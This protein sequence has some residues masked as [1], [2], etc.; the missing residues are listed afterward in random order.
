MLNEIDC[1]LVG[2][3]VPNTHDRNQGIHLFVEEKKIHKCF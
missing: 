2:G 3:D 1:M